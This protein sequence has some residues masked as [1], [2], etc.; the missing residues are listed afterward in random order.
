MSTTL[1]GP[2]GSRGRQAAVATRIADNAVVT[3]SAQGLHGQP[4][5][6]AE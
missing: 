3:A 6:T 2:R 4:P 1:A 5:V